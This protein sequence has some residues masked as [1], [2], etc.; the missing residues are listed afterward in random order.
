VHLI[1]LYIPR[2]KTGVLPTSIVLMPDCDSPNPLGIPRQPTKP[3]SGP[4]FASR[5]NSHR[6]WH[7]FCAVKVT[8]DVSCAKFIAIPYPFWYGLSAAMH[9]QC[10]AALTQD[11]CMTKYTGAQWELGC[12]HTRLQPMSNGSEPM[13]FLA[14]MLCIYLGSR[15]LSCRPPYGTAKCASE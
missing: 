10:R 11:G 8:M 13:K 14:N 9:F 3:N 5:V 4:L 15:Q 7:C 6:N 2:L 1:R 12:M